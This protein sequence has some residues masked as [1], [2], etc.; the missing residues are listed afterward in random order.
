MDKPK[1]LKLLEE[2]KDAAIKLYQDEQ[3]E[4]ADPM[5]ESAEWARSQYQKVRQK[6]LDF[7]AGGRV[8]TN[9]NGLEG[10]RCPK[11]GSN[12]PFEIAVE[13]VVKMFDEGSDPGE[14]G[15]QEWNEDSYCSCCACHFTGKVKDFD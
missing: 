14:D 5:R 13:V 1:A 15:D 9:T 2:L 10:M 11:C 3:H 8:P 4:Y 12:E 7:M 6:V